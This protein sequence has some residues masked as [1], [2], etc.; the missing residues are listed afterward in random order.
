LQATGFSR[1]DKLRAFCN[2]LK[3]QQTACKAEGLK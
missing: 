3:K 1:A 2:R